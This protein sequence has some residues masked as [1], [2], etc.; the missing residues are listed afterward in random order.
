M[1]KTPL[2]YLDDILESV[3]VILEYT[4]DMSKE[5]F[6]TSMK[7]QDAVIRRFIVIGEAVARLSSEFKAKY[8]EVPWHQMYGMR[9]HIIHGYE[10]INL[11]TIWDTSKN[12][13]PGLRPQI[14]EIIAKE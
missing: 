1:T 8:P 13:L 9:N 6:F 2:I 5:E 12:M 10:A 14:E 11:N 3:Q 4:E 7:D